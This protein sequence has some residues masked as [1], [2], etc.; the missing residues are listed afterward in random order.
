LQGHAAP[1]LYAAWA[2]AGNFPVSELTKLRDLRSDL[3]GVW[4]W[5]RSL[6]PLS[7]LLEMRWHIHSLQAIRPTLAFH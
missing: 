2:E 7:S 6:S 4:W 3:E 1:I 5:H